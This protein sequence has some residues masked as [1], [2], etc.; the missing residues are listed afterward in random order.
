MQIYSTN[1]MFLT[2]FKTLI[3]EYKLSNEHD[4]VIFDHTSGKIAICHISDERNGNDNPLLPF[5]PGYHALISEHDFYLYIK[6]GRGNELF[7]K[8]TLHLNHTE[9]KI[10]TLLLA[11][12]E[13]SYIAKVMQANVTK[14]YAIKRRVLN[15]L[16][17]RKL[18]ELV[19]VIN[20]WKKNKHLITALSYS[21]NKI[22]I[23]IS[24]REASVSSTPLTKDHTCDFN[25]SGLNP[26]T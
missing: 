18:T 26:L 24:R 22:H 21:E 6:S 1:N 20:A 19:T 13:V 12:F 25:P 9:K 8:R 23:T 11:E 5:V 2:G 7:S 14:I 4:V 3:K 16:G 15:K 10:L 17:F